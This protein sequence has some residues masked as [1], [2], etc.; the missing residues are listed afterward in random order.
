[1]SVLVVRALR[2][3][4]YRVLLR[5]AGSMNALKKFTFAVLILEFGFELLHF[6]IELN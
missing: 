6:P 2:T 5:A 1:M 4:M 3:L